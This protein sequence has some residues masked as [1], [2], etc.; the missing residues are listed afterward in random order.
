MSELRAATSGVATVSLFS[1]AIGKM[2]IRVAATIVECDKAG[3]KK[4]HAA[5]TPL[6]QAGPYVRI[7]W[8]IGQ[9]RHVR[10]GSEAENVAASK[11]FPLLPHERTL[12]GAVSTAEK[13]Q[14]QTFASAFGLSAKVP[15]ANRFSRSPGTIYI[16]VP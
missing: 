9:G 16:L 12:S 2:A 6:C 5:R 10:F 11:C 15:I 14:E 1:R 4:R 3:G 8:E 13:C 7:W